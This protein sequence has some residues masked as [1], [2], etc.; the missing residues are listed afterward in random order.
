[1]TQMKIFSILCIDDDED[2][3]YMVERINRKMQITDN[4][5]KNFSGEDGLTFLRECLQKKQEQKPFI[6]PSLILLDI[7]M[8]KMNGA[9]FLAGF[10]QLRQKDEIFFAEIAIA[11]FTSS[12]DPIDKEKCLSW[13]FVQG[14]LQKPI[15]KEA[16]LACVQNYLDRKKK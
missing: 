9:E 8:P 13:S 12:D 2:I 16:F 15:E 3:Q 7:N 4:L 10:D 1:M 11:M 5:F 14:F 6:L